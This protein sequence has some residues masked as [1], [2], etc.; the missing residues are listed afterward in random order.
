MPRIR[1]CPARNFQLNVPMTLMGFRDWVWAALVLLPLLV[2]GAAWAPGSSSFWNDGVEGYH[3]VLLGGIAVVYA[4]F[5]RVV[6]AVARR[7]T[8]R[9]DTLYDP[10]TGLPMRELFGDRLK[11]VILMSDRDGSVVPV[12]V[13]G[14]DRFEE[15]RNALGHDKTAGLIKQLGGRLGQ[16][17]RES[18]TLARTGESEFAVLLPSARDAE[19][20]HIVVRKLSEGLHAPFEIDGVIVEAQ[21]TFGVV[22][23]PEHG[24]EVDELLRHGSAAIALARLDGTRSEMYSADMD[25]LTQSRVELIAELRKAIDL[26]QLVLFYQPKSSLAEGRVSGVEALVRWMHPER[27]LIPPDLFIPLAEETDLMRPLTRYVLE[28]A[29]KQLSE[30]R[31]RGLD[32]TV[33][34]NISARNLADPELAP[35]IAA[36]LEKWSVEPGWLELEV[37]ETTVMN[38][39]SRA[40]IALQS[41]ADMGIRLSIDD[42]GT[43]YTSLAYLRRL[44]IDGLKIDRLFVQNVN[45]QEK[46]EVIVRSTIEMGRGLGLHIVAE[47]VETQEV[48]DKLQEMGCDLAQGYFV[49]RPVPAAEVVFN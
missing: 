45:E 22:V 10:E 31:L 15:I 6:D 4:V 25:D 19:G 13:V 5:L 32:V 37:T 7:S 2:V 16:L 39:Q 41:L 49:S 18:D 48:W 24:R 26:S 33:A 36:L 23:A 3:L 47:G 40:A 17:L 38:D 11:Q 14:I 43:G 29:V 9:I 46:D 44:P 28:E 21:A 8:H 20:A 42:Y 34:V 1:M 12:L 27:G 35:D 30:W